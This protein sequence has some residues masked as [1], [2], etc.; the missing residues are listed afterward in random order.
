M[1][2]GE[3]VIKFVTSLEIENNRYS[4]LMLALTDARN[5]SMYNAKKGD[6][7]L[8]FFENRNSFINPF[9]LINVINYLLILDMIGEIFTSNS[10]KTRKIFNSLKRFSNLIEKDI[11]VII[12]LRNSLAHNY[13]LINIPTHEKYNLDQ[14]H[15]FMLISNRSNNLIDYPTVPW[16]G[17]YND[18][19]DYSY[20]R[21]GLVNLFELV[22]EVYSN[23][24]TEVQNDPLSILSLKQGVKELKARF[25]I[26]Y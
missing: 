20:T 11:H 26:I 12:A 4:C 5:L 25:T 8:E 21:I 1:G 10:N 13:G 9:S 22:E 15:K 24:K 14:R 19:S 3:F 2:D 16:T 23:L 17:E 7:E 6:I 18:R